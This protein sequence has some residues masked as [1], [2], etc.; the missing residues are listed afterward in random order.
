MPGKKF[1]KTE[2]IDKIYQSAEMNKQDI[3]HVVDSVFETLKDMLIEGNAIELRGFGS[4]DVRIRKGRKNARN[5]R[6]GE[7]VDAHPHGIVVFKPGK[8]LKHS[9]WDLNE[10]QKEQLAED[11]TEN[12]LSTN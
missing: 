4:F 6:T 10:A 2:I 5:P 3:K 1:S 12:N 7:Q 11:S 8:E 9:V